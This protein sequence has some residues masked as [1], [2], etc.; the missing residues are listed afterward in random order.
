MPTGMPT[1]LN[2]NQGPKETTSQ[3]TELRGCA[4]VRMNAEDILQL[5]RAE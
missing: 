3:P 4:T 5:T 2:G 1:K